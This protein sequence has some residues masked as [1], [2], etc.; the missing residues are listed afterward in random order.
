MPR[1]AGSKDILPRRSGPK[2][3]LKARGCDIIQVTANLLNDAEV[4][5]KIKAELIS[6]MLPYIWTKYQPVKASAKQDGDEEPEN[7]PLLSADEILAKLDAAK[8]KQN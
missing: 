5:P 6:N 3:S 1:K 2:Q 4:E 8:E 7:V